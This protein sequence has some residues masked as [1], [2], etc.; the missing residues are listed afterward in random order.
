MAEKDKTVDGLLQ[1]VSP[2]QILADTTLPIEK[3]SLSRGMALNR[4]EKVCNL[5][6][7]G[8]KICFSAHFRTFLSTRSTQI[9][10]I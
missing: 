3:K 2:S 4:F 8:V 7:L 9:C 6:L 5:N 1:R 10:R